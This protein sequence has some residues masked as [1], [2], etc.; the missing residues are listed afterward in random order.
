M[1][2]SCRVSCFTVS[3]TVTVTAQG[4]A[5]RGEKANDG[6][7]EDEEEK[8]KRAG[9]CEQLERETGGGE[10][11]IRKILVNVGLERF[12]SVVWLFPKTQ[13]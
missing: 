8:G 2:V 12:R 13:S 10:N 5:K 1:T 6:I 7:D 9:I 11:N 4:K 3:A